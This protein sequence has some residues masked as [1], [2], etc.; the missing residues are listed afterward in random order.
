MFI[1]SLCFPQLS[2]IRGVEYVDGI[3]ELGQKFI[4]VYHTEM[5][6][7]PEIECC[8]D[9]Q[10]LHGDLLKTDWSD[11]DIIYISSV[12]FSSEMLDGIMGMV[13]ECKKGTRVI[14]INNAM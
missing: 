2:K 6:N 1:A 5:E 3:Q 10:I 4:D 7:H 8:K 12:W 9:I 13:D 14:H 11:A